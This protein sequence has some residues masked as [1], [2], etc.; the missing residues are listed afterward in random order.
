METCL[1]PMDFT[2]PV[3]PKT[4]RPHK[5]VYKPPY[6][7]GQWIKGTGKWQFDQVICSNAESPMVKVQAKVLPYQYL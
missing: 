5:N 4:F 1:G 2:A 3:D 7:G 6:G